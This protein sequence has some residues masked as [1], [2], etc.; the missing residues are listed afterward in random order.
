ML[1]SAI[2]S[3][4]LSRRAIVATRFYSEVSETTSI[5]ARLRDDLKV[6]MRAKNMKQLTLVKALLSSITY[7]EKDPKNK[8]GD[9]KTNDS[10]VITLLQAAIIQRE[11]SITEFTKASRQDLAAHEQE[12]IDSIAKYI[13]KQLTDAEIKDVL[14]RV[15]QEQ[16]ATELRHIGQ[17]TKA[18]NIDPNTAHR[19]RILAFAKQLLSPPD[20]I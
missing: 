16:G 15:I 2:I 17:V 20:K 7:A 19:S 4:A 5:Y 14:T 1:R 9:L 13:P 12:Q 8:A 10:A 18:S 3:C 11:E 6:N